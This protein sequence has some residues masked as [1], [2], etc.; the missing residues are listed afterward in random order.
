MTIFRPSY[1]KFSTSVFFFR[2][3][4]N[5]VY[6]LILVR[7]QH[8]MSLKRIFRRGPLLFSDFYYYI[9]S[10]VVIRT[11]IIVNIIIILLIPFIHLTVIF[12]S[13]LSIAIS[14]LP[15]VNSRISWKSPVQ[16]NT[17]ITWFSWK[18]AVFENMQCS[19]KFPKFRK[20]RDV[21]ENGRYGM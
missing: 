18:H 11:I 6:G 3:E 1:W 19:W 9:I 7:K 17:R 5:L 21:H 20:M 12:I 10:I 13:M 2:L 4:W 16:E 15:F 8:R 14:N